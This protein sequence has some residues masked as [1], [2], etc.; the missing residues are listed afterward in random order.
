VEHLRKELLFFE[1]EKKPERE[2][3]IQRPRYEGVA[4]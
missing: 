1:K 4:S 2:K 3:G